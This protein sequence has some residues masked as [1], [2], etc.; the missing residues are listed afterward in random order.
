MET[1]RRSLIWSFLICPIM[2]FGQIKKNSLI[3]FWT[4]KER[5]QKV[6]GMSFGILSIEQWEDNQASV[7]VNGLRLELIGPGI[8]VPLIPRSPVVEH[9]SVLVAYKANSKINGLALSGSGMIC[10]C[11]VSGLNLGLVGKIDYGTNGLSAAMF[12]FSQIH[13]GFQLGMFSETFLSKGL[14][15]GV[16]NH[17][18]RVRGVQVGIVNGGTKVKGLQ[19]GFFNKAA[20]LKG[21]QLG[22][23]NV[24]DKRKLPIVNWAL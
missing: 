12:N 11:Q 10:E 18:G 17:G 20:E 9:D 19:I 1:F 13:N 23:W 3:S 5:V 21:L 7:N 15:L 14:Q 4:I 16:A 24:N 8:I 2:T 6:N 22:L